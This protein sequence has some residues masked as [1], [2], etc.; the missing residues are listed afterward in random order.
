MMK[1]NQNQTMRI[2]KVNPSCGVTC[3]WQ[4]LLF[5]L[6]L[7]KYISQPE[8]GSMHLHFFKIIWYPKEMF[9]VIVGY[10]WVKGHWEVHKSQ[11][12]FHRGFHNIVLNSYFV[13]GM[14]KKNSQKIK[15]EFQMIILIK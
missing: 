5:F 15:K 12:T 8:E 7:F 11:S 9:H 1:W 10:H 2:V 6:L 14:K 3:F 13:P 4:K